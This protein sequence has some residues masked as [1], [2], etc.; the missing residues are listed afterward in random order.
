MSFEPGWTNKNGD[1]I[2]NSIDKST[3]VLRCHL[4]GM[5]FV[6]S[7]YGLQC[8]GCPNCRT[9]HTNR[10]CRENYQKKHD[11]SK[12][13][14]CSDDSEMD[15]M[16]KQSILDPVKMFQRMK[17]RRNDPEYRERLDELALG[18]N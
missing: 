2:I 5:S 10:C 7:S 9:A 17:K 3:H 8:N 13:L 6:A 4:C 15:F 16:D 14:Y 18:R 1:T 12:S 11:L